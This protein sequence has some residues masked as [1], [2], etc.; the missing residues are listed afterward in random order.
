MKQ[1]RYK[2]LVNCIKWGLLALA[3]ISWFLFLN[4][5]AIHMINSDMSSELVLSKLLNEEKSLLSKNWYY[6]TELRVLNN[7]L[8]FAPLF[9][10]TDNW[11]LVRLIG[12]LIL[13]IILLISYYFFSKQFDLN[14][15]PIFALILLCPL[16]YTYFDAILM[17]AF[18]I[19]HIIITFISLGL[20][21]KYIKTDNKL[22][23]IYLIFTLILAV[24]AGMGGLRQLLI[25]YLPLCITAFGSYLINKIYYKGNFNLE[26]NK[27]LIRSITSSGMLL[28]C[29][30][31]GYLINSKIFSKLYSFMEYEQINFTEFSFSKLEMILNGWLNVFG[32][33]ANVNI[34]SVKNIITNILSAVLMVFIIYSIVNIKKNKDKFTYTQ[35]FL[36]IYFVVSMLIISMLYLFTDMSYSDRY[37]IPIS[38]IFIPVVAIFINQVNKKI[39]TRIYI[40]II[41]FTL[42]VSNLY[43]INHK[44]NENEELINIASTLIEN[45]YENGYATFWNANVLTEIS[46]G[47]ISVWDCTTDSEGK[48]EIDNIY[49]WLQLKSHELTKPKNKV[50]ILLT[51]EQKANTKFLEPT[52]KLNIL[53]ESDSFCVIGFGDYASLE[54]MIAS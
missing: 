33:Q 52:E 11:H 46:N 51:N 9:S 30:F 2:I 22:S 47:K 23:Y 4:Q 32:Y 1:N 6:S 10:L 31:I 12:T 44:T 35:L 20:I 3:L 54:K 36:V 42:L 13:I 27:F 16:S 18:Y 43:Y 21:A 53:Y 15:F 49:P 48:L 28:A 26:K 17:G 45:G 5:Y 41:I 7:Q 40:V 38:I 29:A 19:P 34:F 39:Q 14:N 37:F 50:F 24:I 25:L 8:I